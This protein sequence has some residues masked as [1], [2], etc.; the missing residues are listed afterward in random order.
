[1]GPSM[2]R[3]D[4]AFRLARGRDG[5]SPIQKS[6]SAPSLAGPIAV[7]RRRKIP[8]HIAACK[9]KPQRR[10]GPPQYE[11]DERHHLAGVENELLP[12]RQR[13]YFSRP[14]TEVE[15]KQDLSR[16]NNM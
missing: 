4:G 15:L 11:W 5:G 2:L 10:I 3:S 1:M 8:S 6:A 7:A 13:N 9:R 14:H 16:R 12:K